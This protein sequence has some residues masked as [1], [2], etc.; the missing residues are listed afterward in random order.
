MRLHRST[1]LATTLTL[2]RGA[3]EA[4]Q[5]AVPP[6]GELEPAPPMPTI[7]EP[8]AAAAWTPAGYRAEVV[9][10]DL[11]YPS[12]VEFDDGGAMYVAESGFVYGDPAAP[13][14]VLRI[15]QDGTLDVVAGGL[16]GPVTDLLWHDGRLYIS[17]RGKISMLDPGG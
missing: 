12:S 4:V 3:C 14:R 9:V 1:L 11:I 5:T 2:S 17:H 6:V 10:K 15:T 8:D 13:A 7:P 16:N